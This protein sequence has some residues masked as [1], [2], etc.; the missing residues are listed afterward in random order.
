MEF[1]RKGLRQTIE[2][3]PTPR[4]VKQLKSYL[5]LMSYYRRFV[6]NF[7]RIATSL[8]KLL[9]KDVAYEWSGE[10]ERAFQTLKGKL[11]SPP[12]FKYP[13][14][15]RSFILT[16]DASGEGLGAVLSQGD[17]GKDLPVAFASRT[18]NQAEKNY[19]TTEKELLAIV[20]GMRYFRPYLYGKQFLVVTDHKPLTW[21][22]NVKDP[23][24]LLLRWRIKLEEYD[25]EVVY[26][27]GTLNTNADALSRNSSLK[28]AKETPE[29][30]RESVINRETKETILYEYHD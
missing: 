5:G 17:L 20:W 9:K 30:N 26:R 16:T 7:S 19:S 10:H 4:S 22:M 18:L 1:C 12:V 13:D 2:D 27:K 3:Y 23:G 15:N 28:G 25:Y 8:H 14:F 24:S 21:I 11:I 29:E 6:S